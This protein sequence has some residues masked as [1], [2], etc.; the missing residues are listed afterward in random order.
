MPF[1]SLPLGTLVSIPEESDPDSKVQHRVDLSSDTADSACPTPRPLQIERPIPH[2]PH[3]P[4]RRSSNSHKEAER[5]CGICF[6]VAVS[7]VRTLCCAHIFCA[8]HI[9]SWLH[10]PV[11]DGLCPTCCVPTDATTL[12]TLGHPTFLHPVPRA[13]PPSRA[14]S[15]SSNDST[16][17]TRPYASYPSTPAAFPKTDLSSEEE[18]ATDFS[19]PALVHARALQ[20]R[21]H[22]P[23]TFS[24]VL[25]VRGALVSVARVTGW[26]VIV[27]LLAGRGSE[28]WAAD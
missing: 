2:R 7:P 23:H 11:S 13:P 15:P 20:T 6:E 28:R 4:I 18:D 3:R 21:R 22:A 9:A 14:P 26:L 17:P 8:E 5:D 19:L 27:A 12:L 1:P 25:G 16:S 24:S 10:G